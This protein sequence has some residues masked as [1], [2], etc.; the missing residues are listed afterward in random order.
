MAQLS[1]KVQAFIGKTKKTTVSK[2]TI[3]LTI[4]QEEIKVINPKEK[5]TDNL[6]INLFFKAIRELDI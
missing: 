1:T 4:L 2:I 6:K 5:P 3:I